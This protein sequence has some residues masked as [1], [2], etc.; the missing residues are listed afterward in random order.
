[1]NILI[2]GSL[3]QSKDEEKLYNTII[4]VCKDFSTNVRSPIDTALFKGSYRERYERAFKAVAETDLVIGEQSLPSTGQGMEIRECA[5]LGKPLVVV[6]RQGS[7]VSGLVQ[8]CPI[9]RDIIFYSN[10]EDLKKKLSRTLSI[11]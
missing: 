3:P 9:T 8:G 7:K 6:A 5:N 11:F 10:I 2:L 1:M 4:S